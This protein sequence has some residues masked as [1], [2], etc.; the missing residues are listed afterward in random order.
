M[1]GSKIL[2]FVTK[3]HD[4]RS[5]NRLAVKE[6][7]QILYYC[8]KRKRKQSNVSMMLVE[9]TSV[10]TSVNVLTNTLNRKTM[11][12]LPLKPCKVFVLRQPHSSESLFYGEP[13]ICSRNYFELDVL[14]EA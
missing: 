11:I 12:L 3:M 13:T 2:N 6:D 1:K 7:F 10:D 4:Q 5:M 9:P 14:P 8:S